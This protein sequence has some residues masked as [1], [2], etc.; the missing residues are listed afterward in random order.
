MIRAVIRHGQIEPLGALPAEWSEG[1]EVIVE[2]DGPSDDPSDIRHWYAAWSA[3]RMS[4]THEDHHALSEALDRIHQTGK[5]Q[6]RQ[7]MGL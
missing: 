7:E 6:M 5:D 4:M 1:Q 2:S 3:S